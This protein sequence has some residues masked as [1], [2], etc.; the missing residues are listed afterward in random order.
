MQNEDIPGVNATFSALTHDGVGYVKLYTTFAPTL[1][2]ITLMEG[3]TPLST[4]PLAFQ[5]CEC[6]AGQGTCMHRQ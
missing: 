3:P 6:R 5:T 1:K 2:N 4:F